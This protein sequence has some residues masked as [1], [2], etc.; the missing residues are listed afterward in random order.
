MSL[1]FTYREKL[2]KTCGKVTEVTRGDLRQLDPNQ[3]CWGHEEDDERPDP[4]SNDR[5]KKAGRPR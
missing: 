2:C 4:I 3:V 1:F 5:R